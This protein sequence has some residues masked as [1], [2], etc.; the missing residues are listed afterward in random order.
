MASDS[1][2][3]VHADLLNAKLSLDVALSGTSE[4]PA[5]HVRDAKERVDSALEKVNDV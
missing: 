2:D 5:K 1:D 3:D 4:N